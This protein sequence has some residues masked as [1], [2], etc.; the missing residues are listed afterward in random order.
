[1]S[2]YAKIVSSLSCRTISGVLFIAMLL[3]TSLVALPGIAA[4]KAVV[5][6]PPSADATKADRSATLVVAG[7]CFWGVQGVFQHVKG[8]ESAVSGYT[9]GSAS[10][11]K[12]SRVGLGNTGHAEAVQIRYDPQQVSAATL[13]QVFFSVAHDPTQLDRQGPD[14]G[15]QYR[16]AVF[17]ANAAQ[18]ALVTA[19][20]AQLDAAKL[21]NDPIV[22]RV[23]ALDAFY[24]AEAYHQD[25]LSLHPENPYIAINDLPK[26]RNLKALFPALFRDKPVLVADATR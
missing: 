10:T 14:R 19:Y 8:V 15:S 24:P 23:D 11:A 6:P 18:R 2:R 7:G 25:Y 13:L 22:T 16:S 5:I 21:W 17:P 20:I 3:M 26:V 9:G 4:E 1:M 12:Y